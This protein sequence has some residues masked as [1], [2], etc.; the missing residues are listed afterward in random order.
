M[1]VFMHAFVLGVCKV[2]VCVHVF[3]LSCCIL[4]LYLV[5]VN[6]NGE[7]DE[8]EDEEGGREGIILLYL[9]LQPTG[10]SLLPL[11]GNLRTHR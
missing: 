6:G 8:K 2:R 5:G 7:E 3:C 1:I 11:A 10:T 4:L 9:F